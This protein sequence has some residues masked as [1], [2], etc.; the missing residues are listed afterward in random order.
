MIIVVAIIGIL[1]AIAIPNFLKYQLR[2]KFG[3]LPTNVNALFKA[4][5]S[6]RAVRAYHPVARAFP[7]HVA[8][9]TR[10][11]GHPPGTSDPSTTRAAPGRTPR[12]TT[13]RNH[14][15]GSS[16]AG[17]T[18]ATGS[19]VAR[20][21]APRTFGTPAHPLGTPRTSTATPTWAASP[22]SSPPSTPAGNHDAACRRT[23]NAGCLRRAGRFH[24]PPCA[25]STTTHS[26]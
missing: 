22:S 11:F 7:S 2:A 3:E 20:A 21:I 14:S 25:A 4:E 23:G 13:A 26:R 1:A 18:A 10:F 5:E 19:A 6:L 16:K 8:S 24:G 12:L 17:P 9:T 15:T